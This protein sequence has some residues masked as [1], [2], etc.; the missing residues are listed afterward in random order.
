MNYMYYELDDMTDNE[1]LEYVQKKIDNSEDF[2]K[3][4]IM[5]Y[6]T[7]CKRHGDVK[8][9]EMM[10]FKEV[11]TLKTIKE[12][13]SE[14]AA[15]YNTYGLDSAISKYKEKELFDNNKK[16]LYKAKELS[17]MARYVI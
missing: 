15:I 10:Q 11:V 6:A 13:I 2:T 3:A 12:K 1:M 16:H 9:K 17:A 4:H 14:L 5:V 7:L 8:A